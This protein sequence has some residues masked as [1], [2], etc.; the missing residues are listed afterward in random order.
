VT[1]NPHVLISI[2]TIAIMILPILFILG[3]FSSTL[4]YPILTIYSDDCSL[5]FT[6][7][8]IIT[9]IALLLPPPPNKKKRSI[10]LFTIKSIW[11]KFAKPKLTDEIEFD[12]NMV[13]FATVKESTKATPLDD[14]IINEDLAI[15]GSSSFNN[16]QQP[17]NYEFVCS[18]PPRKNAKMR[19]LFSKLKAPFIKIR[20]IFSKISIFKHH[21]FTLVFALFLTGTNSIKVNWIS[22]RFGGASFE[23]RIKPQSQLQLL[24]KNEIK[25]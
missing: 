13:H 12:N 10:F 23:S 4:V 8:G 2:S 1:K 21:F 3:I 19:L 17:Q 20:S 5:F 7:S 16:D 9:L 25:R 18:I 15:T 6:I 14:E 22:N 11:K 24:V